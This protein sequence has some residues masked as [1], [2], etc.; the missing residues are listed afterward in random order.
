MPN[1]LTQFAK[2]LE[3]LADKYGVVDFAMCGVT[4]D[5]QD[6]RDV[7]IGEDGMSMSNRHRRLFLSG[8]ITEMLHDLVQDRP[9][10]LEE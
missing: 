8:Q 2:D 4:V 5:G 7:R 9:Q 1:E 3:A 10:P 6:V